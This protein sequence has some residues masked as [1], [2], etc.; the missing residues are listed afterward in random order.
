MVNEIARRGDGVKDVAFSVTDC[1][2][3]YEVRK[4]K[5]DLLVL[6]TWKQEI[7]NLFYRKQSPRVQSPLRL[8]RRS[9]MRMVPLL[10]QLWLL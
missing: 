6:G 7:T 5:L 9:L 10:S 8:L 2:A 3:V 4:K 1:R